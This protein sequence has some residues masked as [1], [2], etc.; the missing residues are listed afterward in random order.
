MIKTN[1]EFLCTDVTCIFKY[2]GYN[3]QSHSKPGMCKLN[4]TIAKQI[5]EEYGVT[6]CEFGMGQTELDISVK[7]N[8][9]KTINQMVREE[10][11]N[12]NL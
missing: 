10:K 6:T 8:I 7:R 1:R 3:T 2:L 9:Y 5:F 11:A 12:G 4:N